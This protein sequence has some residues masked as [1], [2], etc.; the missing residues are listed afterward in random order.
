MNKL[1]AATCKRQADSLGGTFYGGGELKIYSGSQP[2]TADT[3]PT[4][5]LIVTIT[6]PATPF[7]AA[8]NAAPSVAAKQGVW[9]GAAVASVD[10]GGAGSP[11]WFRIKTSGGADPI[12]GVVGAVGSGAQLEL[13]VLNITS[14]QTVNVNSGTMTQLA[15]V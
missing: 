10:L 7:A 9:S 3:A 4:G 15:T 13:D 2:A 12:D 14:G 5:T 1:G 11:G 8:S 6:L